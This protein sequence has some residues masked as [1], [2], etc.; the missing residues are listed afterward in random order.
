MTAHVVR[1]HLTFAPTD[2]GGLISPMTSPTPSLIL[3]F[4]ALGEEAHGA[5]DDVQLGA[6]VDVHGSLLR[7]GTSLDGQLTFWSD[8]GRIYAT[9]GAEFQLSYAGRVVGEGCVCVASHG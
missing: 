9:P 3:R 6:V 2:A 7:P 4:P 5:I 8:L 1:A